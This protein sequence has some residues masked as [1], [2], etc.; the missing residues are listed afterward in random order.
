MKKREVLLLVFLFVISLNVFAG[1]A[2][3]A[4][5]PAKPLT[6]VEPWPPGSAGDTGARIIAEIAKKYFGQPIVVQNVVG[7][8]GVKA[9]RFALNADPDGYTILN[10]WVANHVMRPIFD[11]NIGYSREDFLPIILY[12]INPF[13]LVVTSDHP[14]NNV[15]EFIEWTK[16]ENRTL[17]V[18]ICA[19]VGLP[20]LVMERFL[21]VGGITD[22]N[23][24]PFQGCETE[25]IT[26]LF[27]RSLEFST[28][29]IAVEKI[30]GDRV[31]SLAIFTDERSAIADHIP[32]AKEQGYDLKWGAVAAGWSGLSAPKGVPEEVMKKLVEAFSKAAQSE[33]FQDRMA[34]AGLTVNFMPP[35]EYRQLW[36][37]SHRLLKPPIDE[38]SKKQ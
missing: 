4:D 20:R 13:T 12:Q 17:N 26:G 29:A 11:P 7:G 25:N 32:T 23:P 31:K 16:A 34:K 22:Y 3:A 37:D 8:G 18:G 28:G 30:Y 35:K 15:E 5:Y 9:A 21:K 27:N 14:A 33:E 10:S 19:A 38:L 2:F 1:S 36:D 6:I 24:V